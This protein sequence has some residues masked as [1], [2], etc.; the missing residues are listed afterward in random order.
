M[1]NV[2]H[3]RAYFNILI[4]RRWLIFSFFMIVFLV[5][6][7][8]NF[9]ATPIYQAASR[10][11]IS[12]ENPNLIS[13][14]EVM[15]IDT[16]G[17]DYYQTQYKIIESRTVARNVVRSLDLQ[18]N[19]EFKYEKNFFSG[20]IA[21]IRNTV[22]YIPKKII[23]LLNTGKTNEN[24]INEIESSDSGLVSDFIDRIE[25]TPIRSSRLVDIS[26]EAKDPAM[27]AKLSNALVQAYIDHNLE[28]KLSATKNAV[29]WLSDRIDEQRKKVEV[30]EKKLLSYKE[31]NEIITNF[32]SDAEQITAQKLAQLNSQVIDAEARRVETETRYMQALK[33]KDSPDMLNSIPE[34]IDNKLVG[35]IRKMEVDLYTGMS[36]LSKKYG[37]NHPKMVAIKLELQD[38]EKRK[39]TTVT[40]IINSLRNE[41]E[42]AIARE[43]S[44]KKALAQQKK[45]SLRMNK[46]AI[47]YGVL[48]RE[49]ESSRNMYDLL[50]NR[51]KETSLTE[52]MKT[53]NIRIIDI[54]EV[55]KKPV[56]PRTNQNIILAILVGLSLGIGLAFLIEL[57]DN[58]Y[59]YPDEIKEHLDIPYLATIPDFAKEIQSDDCLDELITISSQKSIASESFRGLRTSILFSS[60]E[61]KPQVLMITGSGINE[62][63]TLIACNLAITMAQAD[64]RTILIDC[65]MRR[66]KIHSF[67]KTCHNT[68][69]SNFL[70]GTVEVNE[71]IFSTDIKNLDIIPAGI[72][73][74][75]PS[76]LIN[77]ANMQRLIN[78]LRQQYKYIIIDTPPI[79]AV[80]DAVALTPMIDGAVI[81]IRAGLT[82][83]NAVQNTL[84]KLNAT[85]CRILGTVL[86]GVTHNNQS[87]YYYQQ[88]AYYH[89]GN[90]PPKPTKKNRFNI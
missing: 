59:K 34:V 3:I 53:G 30:A 12:K 85:N 46:M 15:A 17:S 26:I 70:V 80:S 86:N 4:K 66:P 47:Q 64:F 21:F 76:E 87:S 77:S 24:I 10:I 22:S 13:F 2:N 18:N 75:N 7:L 83:R 62:G 58:T 40:Q 5:T 38:L 8:F 52:E 84:D 27:A 90:N 71:S 20:I 32:S 23:A 89:E 48:Q 72:V 45:E 69:L 37:Q 41:Y 78:T 16:T 54:A 55:P 63:K 25:V 56:R 61:N 39:I 9:S 50:I 74:P 68:G 79:S 67:F 42:L 57:L 1:K 73:P 28:T 88:Y 35:E 36:E 29:L 82:P 60:A 33:L 51:F 49:A 65:D 19:S 6:L 11:E 31:K 81:T 44:L 43:E 14:K